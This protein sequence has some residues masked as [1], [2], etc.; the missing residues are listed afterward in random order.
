[1]T[2]QQ[3]RARL[4][5]SSADGS[6]FLSDVC[7]MLEAISARF[8]SPIEPFRSLADR[9]DQRCANIVGVLPSALTR[10]VGRHR[11]QRV[12]QG[13]TS[14]RIETTLVTVDLLPVPGLPASDTEPVQVVRTYNY[15]LRRCTDHESGKTHP[16]DRV[17][18]GAAG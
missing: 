3:L 7:A 16:L 18:S 6:A 2:G 8:G 13:S 14:G 17:L 5:E 9:E 1:L 12:P 11:A 10:E 4:Q 15:P